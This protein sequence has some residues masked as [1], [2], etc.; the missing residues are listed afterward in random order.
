MRALVLSLTLLLLNI[1]L[2]APA[3]AQSAG[4]SEQGFQT[5]LPYLRSQALAAGVSRSTVERIFPTLIF[6]PR[7]VEL[8]RAQMAGVGGGTTIP[9]FEP[10]RQKHV[11]PSLIQR[12]S[13][14]YSTYREQLAW[15]QRR[16]GVTPSVLIAIWGHETNYGTIMGGFDLL[17]SLATLAYEGR[18][19]QL[20]TDE[21]IAT[22]K[23]VDRGFPRTMLKGSWAGATGHPQFLPSLYLRL[24]VDAD[25]DGRPNIWTSQVDALA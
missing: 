16:Y 19:R 11:T 6:S 23:L 12:G 25:G 24:A 4:L 20:F 15:I 7:T 21:F 3:K 1:Q 5:Y 17:N 8:D 10:Y 22:L 13:Q 2:A 9:A 14:R 18:R